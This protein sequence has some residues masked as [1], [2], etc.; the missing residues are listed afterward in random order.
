[1]NIQASTGNVCVLQINLFYTTFLYHILFSF[2]F[3]KQLP[4]EEG[5][6]RNSRKNN[7]TQLYK[8]YE[9]RSD[10]ILTEEGSLV[11]RKVNFSQA[12]RYKCYLAGMVGYRNNDSY[13]MLNVTGKL[14]M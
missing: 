8:N 11:L 3:L 12:G 5:I 2:F 7:K 4:K 1:M 14:W 13:V 6:I 10:V 9:N